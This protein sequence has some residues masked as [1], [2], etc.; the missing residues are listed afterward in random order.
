VDCIPC[1]VFDNFLI[2]KRAHY[3]Q[4]KFRIPSQKLLFSMT[5]YTYA[6]LTLFPLLLLFALFFPQINAQSVDN[7]NAYFIDHQP[8]EPVDISMMAKEQSQS[9]D[10]WTGFPFEIDYSKL[11]NDNRH[12]IYMLNSRF[13]YTGKNDL[14]SATVAF[15]EI[16]DENGQE[17]IFYPTSQIMMDTIYLWLGHEN[18]SNKNDTLMIDVLHT[19]PLTGYP[20]EEF[21]NHR[22]VITD[23][24]ITNPVVNDWRF[25]AAIVKIHAGNLVGMNRKFA[26]RV[27][28]YGSFLDTFGVV[29]GFRNQGPC[30]NPNV[31]SPTVSTYKSDYYPNSYRLVS[32]AI[33]QYPTPEGADLF[34][35]CNNNGFADTTALGTDWHLQQNFNIKV[36][37][38]YDSM[39]TVP[40]SIDTDAGLSFISVYPNPSSGLF[41][42]ES[43]L[44][45]G[46]SSRLLIKDLSGRQVWSQGLAPRALVQEQVNLNHLPKGMYMI[47]I[48]TTRNT[49]PGRIVIK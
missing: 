10:W 31:Y 23:R 21:L 44:Y 35:D 22:V 4:I 8:F 36:S 42:I 12:V 27:R 46:L 13:P 9:S 14:R 30:T 28:Y 47:Y 34:R 49:I 33:E 48:E 2:L 40:A 19:D 32:D 17:Y 6:S 45:E 37:L 7:K 11:N 43:Q 5:K 3:C 24:S 25:G 26:V 20:T 16:I 18:N 39:S 41:H 1:F 38:R 15:N 29:A